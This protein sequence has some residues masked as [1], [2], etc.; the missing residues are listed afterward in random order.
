MNK[1]L[2]L[3]LLSS[4]LALLY[5]CTMTFTFGSCSALLEMDRK[6]YKQTVDSTYGSQ[7]CNP[8]KVP[9]MHHLDLQY[10]A[11]TASPMHITVKALVLI[12]K[13]VNGLSLE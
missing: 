12:F 4:R 1:E 6:P 7:S 3:S 11:A 2:N 9:K 10:M 13:A 5:T 8:F